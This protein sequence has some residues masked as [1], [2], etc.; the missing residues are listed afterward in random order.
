MGRPG[1][2]AARGRLAALRTAAHWVLL[3][4]V[5]A[6]LGMYV[7]LWNASQ[8][9]GNRMPMPFGWGFSVVLSGSM[10][11]ELSVYDLIAVRPAED[12]A[13]GDVVVYQSRGELIVHRLVELRGDEAVTKGDANPSPDPPISTS[14]IKGRVVGSVP[15]VGAVVQALKTPVG[16]LAVLLAAV[17]LLWLPARKAR[18]DAGA[19]RARILSEIARLR[20][21]HPAA[22][23][24]AG[25]TAGLKEGGGGTPGTSNTPGDVAGN[26]Q[27]GGDTPGTPDTPGNV[28]GGAQPAGHT[29]AG[30]AG[31]NEGGSG[32]PGAADTPGNVAGDAQPTGHTAAGCAGFNE[33][34][35]DMP[36]A[37]NTPG[38]VASDAQPTGHTAGLKEGG[39]DTPGAADT[40]H[41]KEAGAAD[42]PGAAEGS[43][44]R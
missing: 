13:V 5:G 1:K 6:V 24:A 22:G 30:C 16:F 19:E 3:G 40:P 25:H 23:C 17:L 29:A 7:Y 37:P 43:R 39:S 8:L 12:Y 34:G 26:A 42:T 11:P 18:R 28:A 35:S 27:P 4:L 44:Q 2:R 33:G 14:Q 41:E 36:G 21:G 15:G 20:S 10:E 31:F 9:A 32:T 38:N